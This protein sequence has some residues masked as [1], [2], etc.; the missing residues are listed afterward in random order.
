MIDPVVSSKVVR[1]VGYDGIATFQCSD[2]EYVNKNK[3]HLY[4]HIQSKHLDFAGYTC[5]ACHK[6]CK[7]F[8]AYKKHKERYHRDM[9]NTPSSMYQ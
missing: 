2:C 4:S 6:I 8:N 1:C 3:N 9:I 5:V 7:T